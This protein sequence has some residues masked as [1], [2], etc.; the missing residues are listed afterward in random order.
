MTR[1]FKYNEHTFQ[2]PG[3]EYTV[4]DVKRALAATF[5][6]IAQATT[7]TQTAEIT[8]V[9][10]SG[11]KGAAASREALA[12][13]SHD[14]WAHWMEYMFGQGTFNDD[15]TWTMPAEKVDR[16]NRQ[17]ITR[18]A[19]LSEQER[20]SDRHQADKILAVLRQSGGHA[21]PVVRAF[22]NLMETRLRANDHKGGWEDVD[23][24]WPFE[25]LEEKVAEL[26][27]ELYADGCDADLVADLAADVGNY[28]MMIVDLIA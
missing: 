17:V 18:Y 26:K 11:T 23:P 27:A 4:E 15:G 21:R 16:W 25:R 8:F 13:L 19:D 28:A 14:I 1:I 9:K 22:A 3:E 7:E 24:L 10:R 12:D 2:D 6:D 20:E 5:P